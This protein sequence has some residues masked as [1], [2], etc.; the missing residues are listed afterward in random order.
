MG[1]NTNSKLATNNLMVACCID[2]DKNHVELNI[3]SSLIVMPPFFDSLRQELESILNSDLRLT[4][5]PVMQKSA[6]LKRVTELAKKHNVINDSFNYLDD[7]KLNQTIRVLFLK[8][9]RK[10]ILHKYQQ[11]IIS[12][13]N[14]KVYNYHYLNLLIIL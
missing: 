1:I 2:C 5:S 6:A 11:F 13:P 3:D 12:S 7:L 10:N 9:I 4:T 8:T 14:K